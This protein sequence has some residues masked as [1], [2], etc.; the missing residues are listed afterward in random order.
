MKKKSLFIAL[1][2]AVI[3]GATGA[4]SLWAVTH[5]SVFAARIIDSV[6]EKT[7]PS[8]LPV[9]GVVPRVLGIDHPNT[10]LFLFLNNTELRPGGGFIGSYG[11]VTFDHGVPTKMKI[12]GTEKIDDAAPGS[13]E[14][15]PPQA[16]QTYLQSTRWFFRD[17]NWSPDFVT[18]A[19][20]ALQFYAA[21]G[22]AQ[23]AD[24]HTVVAITPEVLQTLMKYTGPITID[25]VTFTSDTISDLLE[26]SVEVDFTHK[27]I[28]TEKRKEILGKL[29]G[30][31]AQRMAV[32]SPTSWGALLQDGFELIKN[33]HVMIYDIDPAVQR[34]LD[35]LQWSGR[36]LP[37]TP[38][39]LQIVDANL[40][41]LKTDRVIDRSAVVSLAQNKTGA[42]EESVAVTYK[43]TG[44][45]DY[46]TTRYRTYLRVF[47]PGNAT[48]LG[49]DGAMSGD[50][51]TKP[52][53][54]GQEHEDG[55][56]SVGAFVSVEPGTSHTVTFRFTP[57]PEV[58]QAIAA[59]H[60][61]LFVQKQLGLPQFDLTIHDD[62]G[63]T[64]G[65]ATPP[66]APA[67]FGDG[68]YDWQGTLKTDQNFSVQ[69]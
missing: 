40:A 58:L 28:P 15:A 64:L 29:A 11:L 16:L 47:V 34:S 33:R 35:A 59:H 61:R 9:G 52:G 57:A 63:T 31:L 4:G 37:G 54:F 1:G 2:L 24:V 44:S 27:Q 30:V 6:I 62:F 3:V 36:M 22:G 53:E 41:A 13:F 42:W 5:S 17:S 39:K 38:D 32:I 26:Y 20:R 21:E 51:I 66:E 10:V 18:D 67:H 43:H 8:A 56:L 19:Q 48:F 25:D 12:E 49:G 46:R 60:Y 68:A 65:Q 45:F 23:A 14:V 55:F 69:W 7:N 50:K